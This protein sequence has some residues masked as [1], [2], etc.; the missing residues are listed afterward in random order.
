MIA[1]LA[2]LALAALALVAVPYPPPDDTVPPLIEPGTCVL[3]AVDLPPAPET[4]EVANLIIRCQLSDDVDRL[5]TFPIAADDKAT[6]L[7][8]A[9]VLERLGPLEDDDEFRPQ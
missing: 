6:V 1:A 5:F 3:E 8:I 4:V 7:S 2:A 9:E